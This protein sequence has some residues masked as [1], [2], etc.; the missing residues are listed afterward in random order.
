MRIN[1]VS[2][3]E[4]AQNRERLI[5][6]EIHGYKRRLKDSRYCSDLTNQSFFAIHNESFRIRSGFICQPDGL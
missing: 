3:S 1:V 6:H 5:L 2:V 4:S